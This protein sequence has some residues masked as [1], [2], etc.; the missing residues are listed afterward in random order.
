MANSHAFE[1]IRFYVLHGNRNMICFGKQN[2]WDKPEPTF[3]YQ[4]DRDLELIG[5]GIP[6]YGLGPGMRQTNI[7]KAL[8]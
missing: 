7:T 4:V 1:N 6:L 5:Q 3:E 2:E 8:T